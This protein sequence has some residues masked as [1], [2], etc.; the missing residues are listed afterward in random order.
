MMKDPLREED[1]SFAREEENNDKN[2]D[3]NIIPREFRP[4]TAS[5]AFGYVLRSP[6]LTLFLIDSSAANRHGVRLM[7]EI[8]GR[9]SY[10]NAAFVD[11]SSVTDIWNFSFLSCLFCSFCWIPCNS[12]VGESQLHWK[13]KHEKERGLCFQGYMGATL[14]IATQ[15][16]LPNTAVDFWRMIY[17]YK[18]KT[19]IMLNVLDP[20]EKVTNCFGANQRETFSQTA[21]LL[22]IPTW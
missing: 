13:Q 20:S 19:V 4:F 8:S 11:V 15:M 22:S 3:P 6:V 7:T 1:L 14:F 12:H 16:P 2:R 18:C 17:D 5:F 21:V 9:N 10:I